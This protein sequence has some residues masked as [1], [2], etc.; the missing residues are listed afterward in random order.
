MKGWIARFVVA[1]SI[2]SCMLPAAQAR[3][4]T[5][6][7]YLT[8]RVTLVISGNFFLCESANGRENLVRMADIEAPEPTQPYG[9]E[10]RR[11]L[12]DLIWQ[13]KIS[14]KVRDQKDEKYENNENNDYVLGEIYY[15]KLNVNRE[16]IRQGYA[17]ANRKNT[18]SIYL[19]IERDAH[20]FGF[21][22][23]HDVEAR[24]PAEFRRENPMDFEDLKKLAQ[25]RDEQIENEAASQ[26]SRNSSKAQTS[27]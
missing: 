3:S 17:W 9:E 11:Y 13:N 7:N 2:A 22:L 1:L 5:R 24:Y 20:S 21:G 23:W 4:W 18:S 8:C 27:R 6:Q 12:R 26:K 16:M 15:R 25:E 19:R 14:I 10:A